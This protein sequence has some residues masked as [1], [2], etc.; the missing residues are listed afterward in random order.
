MEFQTTEYSLAIV[1]CKIIII[2]SL[3]HY[4]FFPFSFFFT[5]LAVAFTV[6]K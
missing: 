4:Y 3:K 6:S 5:N 2:N 1:Y